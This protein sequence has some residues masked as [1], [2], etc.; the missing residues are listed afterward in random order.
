MMI[1]VVRACVF[2][3]CCVLKKLPPY[4]KKL[5]YYISLSGVKYPMMASY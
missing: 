1:V 5:K 4:I 2:K 3:E